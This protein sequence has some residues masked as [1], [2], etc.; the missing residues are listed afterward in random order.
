M[1]NF[2]LNV[3]T[4]SHDGA[5]QG[6]TWLLFWRT[7]SR[8]YITHSTAD[9][10]ASGVIFCTCHDM[11]SFESLR[12]VLPPQYRLQVSPETKNRIASD[13]GIARAMLYENTRMLLYY[14]RNVIIRI[15]HC[16]LNARLGFHHAKKV[17]QKSTV[18]APVE[19][20]RNLDDVQISLCRN[21]NRYKDCWP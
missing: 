8:R 14:L 11:R 16:S 7:E 3:A 20:L 4:I 17:F 6:S 1:K 18:F 2:T 13:Q 10:N 15:L 12:Y 9:Y 19:E 5:D 21:W